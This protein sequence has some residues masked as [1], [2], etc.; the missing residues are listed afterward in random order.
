MNTRCGAISHSYFNGKVGFVPPHFSPQPLLGVDDSSNNGQPGQPPSM[1]YISSDITIHNIM[2]IPTPRP[3]YTPMPTLHFHS[4]W[5]HPNFHANTS[6]PPANDANFPIQ[7]HIRLP[8]LQ[9]PFEGQDPLEW[10]FQDDQFFGFY[11]VPY[12]QHLAILTFYMKGEALSWLI[13]MNAFEQ[14]V[15]GLFVCWKFVLV[16]CQT[17]TIKLNSL[18]YNKWGQLWNI[19]TA[20]NNSLIGSWGLMVTLC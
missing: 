1:F 6:F 10:I 18:S 12:D 2:P 16:L 13:Q 11:Q 15:H 5:R 7:N 8:K 4:A 20:L 19:Y 17:R 9:L 14:P 3:A